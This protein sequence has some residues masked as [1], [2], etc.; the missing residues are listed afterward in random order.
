MPE[1]GFPAKQIGLVRLTLDGAQWTFFQSTTKNQRHPVV[2]LHKYIIF[3]SIVYCF[4]RQVPRRWWNWLLFVSFF[5]L[6]SPLCFMVT[7]AIFFFLYLFRTFNFRD[8][9]V[10]TCF[11]VRLFWNVFCLFFYTDLLLIRYM[12]FVYLLFFRLSTFRK[13][14]SKGGESP[15]EGWCSVW[16]R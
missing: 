16:N 12:F 14:E 7:F 11:H 3:T 5:H 1:H 2:Q 10:N 13:R 9:G 6:A 15:I 8:R 4:T